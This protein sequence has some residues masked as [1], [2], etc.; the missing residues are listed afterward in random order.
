[1]SAAAFDAGQVR[2]VLV[3][4]L[5]HHGDVLL[6]SPVFSVLKN[7]LPG[8]EVDALVYADTAP[9][10]EFHPAIAQIHSID[11]KWKDG[12]LTHQLACER[13]L[14]STLRARRYDLLIH[15]TPH[16]RGAWLARLTGA[17][18]S[19]ALRRSGRFWR[20]SFDRFY[21]QLALRHTVEINLDALRVIGIHPAA[22]ERA[23]T[24]V[25]GQEAEA[26]IDALL[27]SRGVIGR[28]FVLIHP[29]SR[30]TFKCWPARNVA[31]VVR[32][33]QQEGRQVVLTSGPDADERRTIEAITARLAHPVTSFAGELS[34]K[35]M[36]ALIA[37]A[38]VMIGVDSAPMHMAAAVQTPVVAIFGPTNEANWRPWR[39]PQRVVA[40]SSH[41]CR[42]CGADGCGGSKT[43]DC[44]E[45]LPVDAVIQAVRELLAETR[46]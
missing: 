24:L 33:L 12:G 8:V 45:S 14:L 40:S 20:S 31:E 42:P 13:R 35:E 3:V 30:W 9:M 17:G 46:Q 2:R 27:K 34:L 18:Y 21:L 38:E 37:R 36:A 26:R 7:H 4:K 29:A 23:L 6:A 43:S 39:V 10:L 22:D 5:R 15:L 41:S 32:L 25:P 28:D 16:P 11:R 44:L 1:M 19:V